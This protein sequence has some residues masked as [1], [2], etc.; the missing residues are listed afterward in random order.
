MPEKW[1]NDR[2]NAL[3]NRVSQFFDASKD[4]V[5]KMN[6]LDTVEHL[7]IG[8][9]FEDQI[10]DT[11]HEIQ[12]EELDSSSLH[13]VSLRFRLLREHGLWVSPGLYII[14]YMTTA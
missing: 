13:E 10:A 1:L 8:H 5:E 4:M 14:H 6:L 9:H 3:K 2:V 11:L 7:G 12:H